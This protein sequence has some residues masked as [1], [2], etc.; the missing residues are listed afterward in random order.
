MDDFVFIYVHEH[1]Y[2]LI[3]E[4]SKSIEEFTLY[5]PLIVD[6]SKKFRMKY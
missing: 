3:S 5:K 4:N 1:P 2:T 6:A